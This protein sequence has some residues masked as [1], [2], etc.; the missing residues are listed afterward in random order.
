MMKVKKEEVINGTLD[1]EQ[2]SADQKNTIT[3]LG[4][5]R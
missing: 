4:L 1:I 3:D 2:Q 5:D